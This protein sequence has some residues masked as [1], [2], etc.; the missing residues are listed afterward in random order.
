M[1]LCVHHDDTTGQAPHAAGR[2]K[3]QRGL[4]LGSRLVR[5][6][7][8]HAQRGGYTTLTLWTNDILHAAR[9]IYEREGFQLTSE[10]DSPRVRARPHR[11]D[12]VA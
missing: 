10:N 6:V 9:R 3:R 1:V 5:E 11:A 2:A 7:I 12:V 4:G 8:K